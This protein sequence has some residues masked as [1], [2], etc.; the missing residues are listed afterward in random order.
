MRP[1][2]LLSAKVYLEDARSRMP[3][4]LENTYHCL[5]C[6]ALEGHRSR[7]RNLFEKY[8]YPV[9][10]Q[11]PV[12][13]N[14]CARRSWFSLF[15]TLPS[16]EQPPKD[17]LKTLF[18]VKRCSELTSWYIRDLTKNSSAR[19]RNP[20]P[21]PQHDTGADRR[22]WIRLALAIPLF[23]R[24]QD[25]QGKTFLDF[26]TALNFSASGALLAVHRAHRI[27]AHVSLEIP[28]F[29]YPLFL[30]RRAFAIFALKSFA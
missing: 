26:S 10:L 15:T 28:V 25:G 14:K 11:Q 5:D 27:A 7:P 4:L 12:S 9:F 1:S 13:C 20:R 18:K 29:P 23:V 24:S 19:E 21:L 17:R 8:L 22:Q 30:F 16:Q 6:G 2:L 3:S